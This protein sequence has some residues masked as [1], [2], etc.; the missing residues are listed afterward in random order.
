MYP[1]D[2]YR[3]FMLGMADAETEAGVEDEILDGR[4]DSDHLQQIEEELIDDHLFGRLSMDE[5]RIF[6]SE[7]LSTPRRASK[8][9]FARALQHYAV[10]RAP[11]AKRRMHFVKLR[12][13]VAMPWFLPLAGALGC[14]ML[15]VIWLGERNRSLSHELAQATQVNDEHQRVIVSILEERAGRTSQPPASIQ[16][17]E[18]KSGPVSIPDQTA[19][20]PSIRLSPGVSRGLATVP[21]LHVNR[22]A[23]TVSIMIELPFDLVS[24]LREELLSS[25][26]KTIWSQQFS[27]TG[28]ISNHGITTIVLPA[29]L[30]A[31]GEYRL[32]AETGANREEPGG[33]AIY[34]FRIRKD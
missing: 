1:D 16:T 9:E 17:T 5:V 4:I 11:E 24:T 7:F 27:I 28:G 29:G 2:K 14:A 15:A 3:A 31:T 30:L 32:R 13:L 25:E 10:R 21:I 22:E 18:S 23:S 26:D 6:E 8:L 20:Q 12:G 33:T 19:V 34:L